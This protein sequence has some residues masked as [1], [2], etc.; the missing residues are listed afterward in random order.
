MQASLNNFRQKAK[1]LLEK[2]ANL[3]FP[4]CCPS[5]AEPVIGNGKLCATCWGEIDFITDPM[6][7]RCGLPFSHSMGEHGLCGHCIAETPPFVRAMSVFRYDGTSRRQ[8]LAFKFHD[9]TQLAP[10]F[11]QWLTHVA[12]RE[13][14]A[15]AEVIIPVP[16]HYRRLI[17]RR[18]N[19]ASLL[20]QAVSKQTGLPY[21]AHS[22]R[23]KRATMPQTG[24]TREARV[25]N[26]RGAF[27]VPPA[28]KND[29][30]GK[31]VLLVDDVMTTGATLAACTRVLKDAGARDVYV[32]TL[33]RTVLAD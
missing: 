14:V 13:F 28:C 8:V 31:A 2:L 16:L 15:K 22:L 23:R 21:I 11:G 33:A 9:R 25:K 5:C 20:A 1:P 3:F 26:L 4:A 6:C 19:Q 27:M 18:Y 32:L 17:M 29:V 30:E 12:T 10:L 7:H 24:L